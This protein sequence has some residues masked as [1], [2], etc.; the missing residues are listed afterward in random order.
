MLEMSFIGIFSIKS[1]Y[2]FP[3]NRIKTVKQHE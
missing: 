2:L 1:F 3:K